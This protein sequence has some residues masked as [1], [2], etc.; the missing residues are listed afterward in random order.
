MNDAA[1]AA[2]LWR[3]GRRQ[4]ARILCE[5]LA[6][7]QDV[8]ALSLLAEFCVAADQ[9]PAAVANL[10]RLLQLRESDAAVHRRL[11]NALLAQG[12]VE[13][14]VASY[15][16]ALDIEP[17]SARGHGNLGQALM[18]LRSVQ[19]AESE[20][21]RAIE[22]DPSYAI[23][24]NNLGNIH[25]QRRNFEQ[26]L[27]CYQRALALDARLL[28]AHHN[29]ANALLQ[30]NRPTEALEYY[31]RVVELRPASVDVW[32]HRGNALSKL[33]RFEDAVESYERGLQIRPEHAALLSN[34]ASAL[35][36]VNRPEQALEYCQ[37]ALKLE[38]GMPEAF[39]NLAGALRALHRFEEAQTACER[40]LALGDG[41]HRVLALSNMANVMLAQKRV[42]EAIGFC[43]EALALRVELA[44]ARHQRAGALMLDRR[45]AEAARE[46]LQIL[47]IDPG[48]FPFAQGLALNARLTGCDWDGF[49]ETCAQVTETVRAGRS[50]IPPFVFL[51]ISD[52][53]DLQQQCAS[54]FVDNQR[55]LQAKVT[56][57]WTRETRPK[58]H[59]AYLSCDFHQHAT[60]MLTA[61]LFEQH[62][63]NRFETLLVSFGPADDSVLRQ[64]LQSGCD[65]FAD[66]RGMSDAQVVGL[67]RTLEIDIAIDLKGHTADSRPEILARRVA[68]IQVS[69]LGY[70]GT[71][72]MEQI[73]YLLADRI[74]L[75]AEQQRWYTE[76]IVYLPDSYQVNDARRVLPQILPSRIEA[77]LPPDGFVFCCF[78]NNWK[79][80]P[81]IFDVWM[82]LLRIVPKSVL[83]LLQ[84]N[85]TAARNLRREAGRRGIA[86][87]RLIFA[88]RL[89]VEPHLARHA[90]ADLFLDTLPYNAHT[91][92][93]DAL[94]T[95]V[96]VLTC[97]GRSFAG[98]VAASLL[99]AVGLPQLITADLQQYRERALE[100]AGDPEQLAA[101]RS[102]LVQGRQTHAL[103]DTE[104][105]C[106]H[107]EQAYITM[108]EGHQRAEP[109]LGFTV[110]PRSGVT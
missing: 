68:P 53:P 7:Q 87:E 95:G 8:E 93:S 89:T 71:M 14:A 27:A 88:P 63:R 48:E 1:E 44:E 104:R 69:Y 13:S 79:I 54:F 58:L 81:T 83:W 85:D 30:L 99:H 12:L 35:L 84:D 82:E 74:V 51:A 60:A 70:P 73:D 77:G 65:R 94:W 29:C 47:T 75:P 86:T 106:R 103:F 49:E 31:D 19:A 39:N 38:H 97:L 24:H 3:S 76:Q 21:R 62:D 26:A 67:L 43:D 42:S 96:P 102:H 59:L 66:V 37:R 108:W 64:R 109:P 22:L 107:L 15:R 25:Q 72:A 110:P 91:T 6:A 92:C 101:L 17:G 33:K 32:W 20:F 50:A 100:L 5:T 46:Y 23:A 4:E 90:L 80:N 56:A 45:P 98:R 9:L 2:A 11:G 57:G 10:H 41:N 18:R 40:S 16:R 52:A 28:E 36:R 55:L 34:C 78:N 105:F 61:G